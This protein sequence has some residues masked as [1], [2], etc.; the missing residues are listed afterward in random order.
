MVR[1]RTQELIRAY[2]EKTGTTLTM[3]A[4]ALGSGLSGSSIHK[5][6]HYPAM[7]MDTRSIDA[8]LTFFSGVL[9]PLNTNDLLEFVPE[10]KDIV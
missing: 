4:L 2:E 10:S 3:S 8:L 9:G 7:R 1:W 5:H 6:M